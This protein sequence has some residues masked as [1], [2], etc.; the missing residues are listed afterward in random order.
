VIV[1]ALMRSLDAYKVM[2]CERFLAAMVLAHAS[3]SGADLEPTPVP[4]PVPMPVPA[5]LSTLASVRVLYGAVLP[6]AR[7]ADTQTMR[8]RVALRET[9][10]LRGDD[11]HH[12]HG[13]APSRRSAVYKTNSRGGDGSSQRCRDESDAYGDAARSALGARQ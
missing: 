6:V 5:F 12:A 4:M 10:V 11:R 13:P 9:A 3:F 1:R 2:F 7:H 8:K